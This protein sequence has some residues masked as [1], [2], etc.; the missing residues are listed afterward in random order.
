MIRGITPY[1]NPNDWQHRKLSGYRNKEPHL[2]S[3]STAH[4]KCDSP[5]V[6]PTFETP[7]LDAAAIAPTGSSADIGEK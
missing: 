4:T 5:T 2:I 3:A 1:D 6:Q 7:P